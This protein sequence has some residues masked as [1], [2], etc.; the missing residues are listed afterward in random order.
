MIFFKEDDSTPLLTK[1][2]QTKGLL[3]KSRDLYEF[4]FNSIK[5]IVTNYTIRNIPYEP[6][7]FKIDKEDAICISIKS[8]WPKYTNKTMLFSFWTKYIKTSKQQLF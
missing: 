5:D 3:I 8:V 2:D 7:K 4:S 6:K 1:F